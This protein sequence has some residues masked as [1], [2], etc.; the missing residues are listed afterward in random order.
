MSERIL[1]VDDDPVQ[2]RLIENMV[3][4]FGYEAVVAEGGDQARAY[5]QWRRRRADRLRRSS[6]W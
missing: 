2:R 6:I 4:K 1:V 3:R 5:S